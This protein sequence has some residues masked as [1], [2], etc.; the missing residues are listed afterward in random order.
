MSWI[1]QGTEGKKGWS[2]VGKI[3]KNIATLDIKAISKIPHTTAAEKRTAMQGA[4]EQI[5]YYQA[6][7]EDLAK[8][9]ADTEEQKKT[10]RTKIGEKEIRARNRIY[11]RSGFMTEPSAAPTDKLG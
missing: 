6:A 1:T 8:T 7:K 4:K 5:N 9:R 11:K 2:K 10:E 3:A